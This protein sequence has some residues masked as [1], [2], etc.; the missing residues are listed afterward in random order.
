M[1]R[2]FPLPVPP[3][4][5]DTPMLNKTKEDKTPNS[6]GM[7]LNEEQIVASEGKWLLHLAMHFCMETQ[8]FIE[9]AAKE[10]LKK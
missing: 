8:G 9:E 2:Y 6:E 7:Y 10:R 3:H 5:Q 4:S 1:K